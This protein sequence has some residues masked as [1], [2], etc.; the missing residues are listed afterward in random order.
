MLGVNELLRCD[1]NVSSSQSLQLCGTLESK[2]AFVYAVT[3]FTKKICVGIK[4]LSY[5]HI[6]DV[7]SFGIVLWSC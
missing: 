2:L 3:W 6:V 4:H 7:F 1:M 5:D